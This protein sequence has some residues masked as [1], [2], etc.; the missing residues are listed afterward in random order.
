MRSII[1]A[2]GKHFGFNGFKQCKLTFI[3]NGK[4]ISMFDN[5]V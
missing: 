1:L 4:Y 3:N 2:N 5:I